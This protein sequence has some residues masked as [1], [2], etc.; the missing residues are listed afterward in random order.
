VLCDLLL[1]DGRGTELLEERLATT[2]SPEVILITG[3]ATVETAIEA[4]RLGAFDY[5]T[6][7]IDIPRL[8]ELLARV[9]R[10]AELKRELAAMHGEL[11][12]RG[13]FGAMIGVSPAM[14]EVYDLIGKVAPTS[15]PVLLVGESGTGKE[16]AAQALHQLSRRSRG[17]FV[18]LNC[19]AVAPG[20]MESELFGHERG[21]FTGAAR[22]HKGLFERAGGGTLFLDEITEMP[23]ELQV[24]LL[25]VL[26]SGQLRRVGGDGSIEL[27]VRVIAATNREPA[28]AISDRK[29]REDLYY[30]L[31]VFPIQMPRS[32]SSAP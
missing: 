28:E 3:H 6:K 8:Q 7:P 17:P 32:S 12:R 18:P 24:K 27:D 10:T 4:M 14:Q 13:R 15:A 26:E 25:R 19:G 5:L 21:S 31:N 20:L 29:L 9:R 30:R 22:Q 1:P 11:E 16:L 2:V 23:L